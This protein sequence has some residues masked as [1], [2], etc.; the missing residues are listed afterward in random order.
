MIDRLIS[1]A[2]ALADRADRFARLFT[3]RSDGD[4]LGVRPGSIGVAAILAIVAV[5]LVVV[6]LDA[7]DDPTPRSFGPA[8]GSAD[9]GNH[10]YA[11]I[12]GSVSSGYVETYADINGNDRKDGGEET[13]AWF[14]FLVDPATRT[15]VTVRSPRPPSEVFRLQRSGEVRDDA[16]Y[17]AED[18]RLFSDSIAD[19][20]VTLD[21]HR[22]ID[23]TVAT[24]STPAPLDIAAGL[25]ADGSVVT[26]AGARSAGWV[27]VCSK[28]PDRDGNCDASEI[29]AYDVLVYDPASKRGVVVV[30]ADSPEFSPAIFT[31]MLRRD[32]HAVS[33]ATGT[34]GLGFAD[35]DIDV[36]TRYLL[37]E[38]NTPASGL[39]AFGLASLCALLAGIIVVGVAGGYL[40]YRGGG[41]SL[42]APATSLGIG[43]RVP[44]LVTGV[45]RTATGPVHVREAPADLVRFQTMVVPGAG[46]A[47]ATGP[48]TP[49]STLIVERRGRREG[50]AV[51]R[52]E[53]TRLSSGTVLPLRGAR[54]AVRLVAGTGPLYLSF[55]TD[56]DR[57]RAAAELLD[58]TALVGHDVAVVATPDP[59]TDKEA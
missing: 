24:G 6:G 51:G 36:S 14:Y 17:V 22:Y 57:D 9:I 28:D 21:D 30:T 43:E 3:R 33:E 20:G 4:P 11:T 23:A 27:P 34:R 8:V 29:D 54:P 48:A 44:L 52:G 31:G 46:E 37:D 53:S 18:L 16:T 13:S 10:A 1:G 15:G 38:G 35:L 32:E 19:L 2:G 5:V 45:L 39:L 47:V 41:R 26:V 40:I 55:D 59:S 42:P 49:A 58:E 12:S 25:P 56:A 7:T 50:V